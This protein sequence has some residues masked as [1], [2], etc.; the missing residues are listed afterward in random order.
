MYV[1]VITNYF[2]NY[3]CEYCY[4]GDLKKI[5]KVINIEKLKKQLDAISIKYKIDEIHCY[6]GEITLLDENFIKDILKCCESYGNTSWVTNMSNPNK[7]DRIAKETNMP[8]ATSF[9]D[10]RPYHNE[11]IYKI[12]MM[13]NRPT[14]I[15]QVVTPSILKKTP[16]EVLEEV[17]KFNVEYLGFVQYFPSVTNTCNYEINM[18]TPNKEYC[19]FL[20]GILKEHAT[21]KYSMKIENIHSLNKVIAGDYTP[22]TDNAIFITPFNEYG[23]VIY[24][25]E[26]YGR[27]HL[28][29]F[30]NIEEIE[31]I[32]K[33]EIKSYKRICKGCKQF[34]YC[35]AEHMRKWKNG[36]ECCGN[37]SL[38]DWYRGNKYEN[39]YKNY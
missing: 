34:G 15:I 36:D 28:H 10:E 33:L 3:N 13:E 38:I 19:N 5:T 8:Y 9:N 29:V 30:N 6:G 31:N 26:D 12:Y 18:D 32:K 21:G 25:N 11:L 16:K 37:K 17:N 24:D 7:V 22:W 4:L 2:C 23:C 39:L 27:E 20:K 14:S 35:Y 1:H